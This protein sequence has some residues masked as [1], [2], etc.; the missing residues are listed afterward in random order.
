VQEARR[1]SA[2]GGA[3]F[4]IGW[5]L[6]ELREGTRMRV[7][8]SRQP[9]ALRRLT[10]LGLLLCLLGLSRGGQAQ[11]ATARIS[12]DATRVEG[13]ISPLLYGQFAEFMFEDIK[14]GLYA[15]L[16]LNRSFEEAPNVIGLS[17]H[18]ERYPDDRN[19]DYGLNFRWADTVSY[20]GRRSE[21][22]Q[23][24]E[25]SLWVE[26]GD[27]VTPRHGLY[28]SRIPVREGL[29]YR[30][31]IW[32]K[33]QDYQGPATVALEADQTGGEIYAAADITNI[34]GDWR[35]YEFTLRA[36]KSDPLARFS[37][38]FGGRGQLWLDQVSLLPGDAVDGVRRDVFERVKALRPAFVRWPG[39]NVAQDYHWRWG[40]GPRDER[41]TW[42]NLSWKNEP[43][44]S[45][46]GTDEYLQFCRNIGAEPALTVNVEGRGATVEEA[47]AWV[48][49]CNGAQTS[50]YG[51]ARAANGH[52]AP[53]N[54]RYWE[55]GNEIWGSWVRG[56]SDAETYARNLNRYAQAMRAVDPTIKFI[57]VGDNDMNWN[58]TV[59][60]QA[61]ANVDY[62]AIHHYYGRHEMKG[63][64]LNLMA[65][66]LHYERFYK[67]VAQLLKELVPGRPIKL[68]I[69]EWGLDLPPE[70]QYSMESA[71][72]GARLMNAF[73]R[74]GDIVALSAVSDLVNGWPGGIIQASR[75]GVFVTPTYWV[76]AIYSNHLGT[77]RLGTQ[78]ESPTFDTTLEG[79]SIPFLDTV[80][81][82]SADGH[83]IYIKA[84]NT[85]QLVA[86]KTSITLKGVA[87][88]PQAEV[89]T[90]TGDHLAAFNSF[91]TPD[92][93]SVKRWTV[94]AGPSFTVELP[95]HSVSVITLTVK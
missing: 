2:T 38:L 1:L 78:V 15:E 64:A 5:I 10:T 87:V 88:G 52:P 72:Y 23:G 92:A 42:V 7:L 9:L 14:G 39:G 37:I 47:A 16:I 73:E 44:P 71:L 91:A 46:F 11:T 66:P 93:V 6:I 18:W 89:E 27:G 95:K 24:P 83:Q 57:A 48:E 41:M 43:E 3:R 31:Y 8:D 34:S 35:K 26:A 29:E 75:H 45:D 53:Y 67:E 54:V 59:L 85:N 77:T 63:D 13:R 21:A 20:P 32:I 58:R 81:S 61:G 94:T 17:R 82:R 86:I 60:R 62:L 90:V 40:V 19:D 30:G 51:A 4:L 74:S 50:K 68:A 84:V 79:K 69:N 80:A 33:S 28:Q 65:R 55:V 25:H 49:Y 22:G 56:H 12:I 76:N 70:R 36:A